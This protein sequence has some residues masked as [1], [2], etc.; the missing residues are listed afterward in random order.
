MR[1]RHHPLQRHRNHQDD[2]PR[3]A[4]VEF[5]LHELAER[6][7]AFRGR[8]TIE[9]LYHET[10]AARDQRSQSSKACG[11]LMHPSGPLPR[12]LPRSFLGCAAR[13][14][15]YEEWAAKALA[16]RATMI[17]AHVLEGRSS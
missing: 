6:R 11:A 17:A 10:D 15:R 14:K 12:K 16:S 13:A 9:D 1:P 3:H 8:Q 5:V 7:H 4:K 2:E